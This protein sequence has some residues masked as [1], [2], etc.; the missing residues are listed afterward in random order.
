MLGRRG[1]E[2]WGLGT[3]CSPG[4]RVGG[5]SM[6][7]S[8]PVPLQLSSQMVFV[9]LP[10]VASLGWSKRQDEFHYENQKFLVPLVL[11]HS[12]GPTVLPGEKPHL[13]QL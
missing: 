13:T 7:C 10:E 5:R 4:T 2:P 6:A 1:E 11:P 9:F 8:P 12:F 3:A